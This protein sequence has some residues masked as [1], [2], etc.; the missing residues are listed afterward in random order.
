M[1]SGDESVW[2]LILFGVI[3]WG[4]FQSFCSNCL[5]FTCSY[6]VSDV[7]C[8]AWTSWNGG[9][10]SWDMNLMIVRVAILFIGVMVWCWLDIGHSWM[11]NSLA[12][13]GAIVKEPTHPELI[14]YKCR[15]TRLKSGMILW[16]GTVN[17]CQN[18]SSIGGSNTS[19]LILPFCF[20]SSPWLPLN[21]WPISEKHYSNMA[22]LIY[23]WSWWMVMDG[24]EWIDGLRRVFFF[25]KQWVL[26]IKYDLD[27][28]IGYLK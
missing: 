13:V 12:P 25:K 11:S 3:S 7:D 1:L 15:I 28:T 9:W 22:D 5:L 18:C 21:C 23:F 24:G 19:P 17:D 16:S 2:W 10:G 14:L 8:G 20:A 4:W 27:H 6:I 26:F